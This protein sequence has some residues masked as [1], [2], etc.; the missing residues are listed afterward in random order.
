MRDRIPRPRF[1]TSSLL[2]LTVVVAAFFVG[3]Q[4]DEIGLRLAQIWQA[5]WP[6]AAAPYRLVT[7][8]DGS[9]LFSATSPVPR[10]QV[11]NPDV[12]SINPLSSTK[13]AIFP[14]SDG[15]QNI[16][17]WHQDG[18]VTDLKWMIRNGK[19]SPAKP[20]DALPAIDVRK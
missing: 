11:N 8:S 12:C 3:R 18:T 14:K 19:F 7:Q 9:L 17:F 20:E 10:V 16:I 1:R 15:Y 4:S 5:I 13:V 2:W 6:S